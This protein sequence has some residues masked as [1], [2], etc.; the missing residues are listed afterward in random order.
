M[1]AKEERCRPNLI[2]PLLSRWGSRL[3]VRLRHQQRHRFGG[4]APRDRR[5]GRAGANLRPLVRG[6][7]G[8]LF[9]SRLQSGRELWRRGGLLPKEPQGPV[10]VHVEGVRG[11]RGGRQGEG[12]REGGAGKRGVGRHAAVQE[13]RQLQPLQHGFADGETLGVTLEDGGR[14]LRAF[15]S[16]VRVPQLLLT[17]LPVGE[18]WRKRKTSLF[19]VIYLFCQLQTKHPVCCYA[20]YL[21]STISL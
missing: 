5:L 13:L 9:D 7:S 16:S 6:V 19:N 10:A 14:L 3:E 17:A 15:G 21:S 18:G 12:E 20:T 4:Q 2:G 8:K 1:L 11:G